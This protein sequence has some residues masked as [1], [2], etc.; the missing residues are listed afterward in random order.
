M[1]ISYQEKKAIFELLQNE[2]A[3]QKAVLFISTKDAK[4][5][6]NSESNF[7]FRKTARQQGIVVR[8]VKNTLLSKVFDIPTLTGQTIVAFLENKEQG[9][10]VTVPK[11]IVTMIDAD[12]KNT[13][14]IVGSVVNGEYLDTSRTQMLA[15]TSTKDESLSKIAG[16]LQSITAKIAIGIKEVPTST[17]RGIAEFSKTI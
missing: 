6:L 11:A 15:H 4:E 8:V 1:A 10:E 12:F 7:N 17:A 3:S 13:F 2:V 9:D 14:S 16:L 5:T